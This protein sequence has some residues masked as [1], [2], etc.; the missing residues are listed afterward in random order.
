MRPYYLRNGTKYLHI[1]T[2]LFEDYQD[3]SDVSGMYNQNYVFSEKKD[4]AKEFHT[5]DDA[6][7]YLTLY[8][9]KLKGFVAVT[10]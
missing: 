4:G 3:Y 1:R 5:K 7:R 9:R 6:E 2:D 10:E 8:K